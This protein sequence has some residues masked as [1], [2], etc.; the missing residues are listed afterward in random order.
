M[1][2]NAGYPFLPRCP[3]ESKLFAAL[4][5][6][7]MGDVPYS[8]PQANLLDDMID[9]MNAEPLAFVVHVGDITSGTG[10]CGDAWMEARR[11]QFARF[12]HPFVLLPGDN[13]WTDC[14]R[15]GFDPMER[16]A[17]WRSLFCFSIAG[18]SLERQPGKYCENVRW[19][20]DKVVFVGLN[21]P[22]GNNN[23]GDDPVEHGERMQAVYAWLDRAEA[24]ARNRDGLVL[25][26]QANPFLKPRLGGANGFEG[27][28]ERLRRLGAA[29]PGKVL[30]V[31]GDTHKYRDD[32]PLPGLRRVEVYGA[33]HIRWA[34]ARVARTGARLFNVEPARQ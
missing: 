16:L 7:L 13:D 32:E 4:A 12:T 34:R 21:I 3:M 1:R 9:R 28:L 22:G 18:F 10:P 20:H 2:D 5:F 25:L 6:A 24:L 14:K 19:E 31:H 26:M 15:T 33:P 8:H 30:L 27:I 29:M 11:K 17:K 23:L